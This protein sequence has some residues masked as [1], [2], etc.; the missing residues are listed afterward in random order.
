TDP[1]TVYAGTAQGNI[2]RSIDAGNTWT[3]VRQSSTPSIGVFALAVD[4]AHPATIYAAVGEDHLVLG[5][6]LCDVSGNGSVLRTRDGGTS[7]TVANVGLPGA[8][9]V[10][11]LAIDPQGSGAVYA[12]I[13][14]PFGLYRSDDGA[15]HWTAV[16]L[17]ASLSS[18]P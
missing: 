3:L 9:S 18:T 7:W 12:L 1:A 8:S 2:Y 5:L 10:P 15:D 14:D 6:Q 4:P 16:G 13:D 17:P 11:R